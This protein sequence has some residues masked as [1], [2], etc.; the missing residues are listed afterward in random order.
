MAFNIQKKKT[1]LTQSEV[2][3]RYRYIEVP[4]KY[5]TTSAYRDVVFLTVKAYGVLPTAR[6]RLI[7]TSNKQYTSPSAMYGVQQ[8]LKDVVFI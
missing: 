8:I 5:K 3:E 6:Y 4:T 7:S 1:T 2:N